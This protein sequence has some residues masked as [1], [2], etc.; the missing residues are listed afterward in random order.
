MSK[1]TGTSLAATVELILGGFLFRQAGG[2][3]MQA[4]QMSSEL[5][6]DLAGP[7]VFGWRAACR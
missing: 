4:I 6:D 2:F 1:V 3:G 5:T 7:V